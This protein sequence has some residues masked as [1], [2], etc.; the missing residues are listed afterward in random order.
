MARGRAARVRQQGPRRGVAIAVIWLRRPS[1]RCQGFKFE[2]TRTEPD[3]QGT[4]G[5]SGLSRDRR[6]RAAHQAVEFLAEEPGPRRSP[7][8]NA[9]LAGRGIGQDPRHGGH[10]RGSV[11]ATGRRNPRV[12]EAVP[13]ARAAIAAARLGGG[14]ARYRLHLTGGP[15]AAA[16]PGTGGSW[17]RSSKADPVIR[18]RVGSSSRAGRARIVQ[19]EDAVDRC[20]GEAQE[21]SRTSWNGS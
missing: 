17:A 2:A 19:T 8:R 15:F 18:S 6:S 9:A 11:Q 14:P 21:L 12:W 16:I 5:S 7:A 20:A 10:R 13:R 3:D 4:A 1:R